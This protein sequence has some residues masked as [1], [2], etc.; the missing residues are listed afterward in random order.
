MKKRKNEQGGFILLL[1]VLVTG[2]LL[3]IAL[4]VFAISLKEVILASYL[5]Q[6]ARAFSAAD[7]MVECVLFWDHSYPQNGLPYT[8]F[9]TSSD[10]VVPA[11]LSS[12]TCNTGTAEQ[13][14][15]DVSETGWAVTSSTFYAT[16]TFALSY[17]DGT[18]AEILVAKN[19]FDEL[20]A[21]ANGYNSCETND[22]RRVQ[23]TIEVKTR[24]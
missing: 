1:A 11:N 7:R 16:T 24:I 9:A 4:G 22:R 13:Q 23:R 21:T 14:L 3:A 5:K 19:E 10:Y 15:S 12:A 6:S 17:S 2:I 18:C 8:V 20:T